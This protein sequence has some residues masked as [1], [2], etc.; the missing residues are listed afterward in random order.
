VVLSLPPPPTTE[1]PVPAYAVGSPSRAAAII[2]D[3]DNIP[4]LFSRK[5]PGGLFLFKL[6]VA[7]GPWFRV[8]ASDNLTDWQPVATNQVREGAI[9]FVDP[10]AATNPHHFY[11][12]VPE[13]NGPPD[14]N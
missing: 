7:E 3:R 2:L 9:H 6:H 11:R 10:Q 8:E 4:G 5:L 12:V 1:N 14:D 13:P